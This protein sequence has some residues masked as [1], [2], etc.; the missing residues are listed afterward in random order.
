MTTMADQGTVSAVE[1][2]VATKQQN[3]NGSDVARVARR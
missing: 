3:E 2:D 1:P